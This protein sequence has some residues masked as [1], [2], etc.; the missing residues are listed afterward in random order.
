MLWLYAAAIAASVWFVTRPVRP[1]WRRLVYA[2]AI[3]LAPSLLARLAGALTADSG[4]F[5]HPIAVTFLL[6][7][8]LF[9][10]GFGLTARLVAYLV[11]RS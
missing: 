9:G 2:V 8:G 1:V 3:A 5:T 10:L 6:V 7:F 11:R 4:Y